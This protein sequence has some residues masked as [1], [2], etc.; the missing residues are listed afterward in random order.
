TGAQGW[1]DHDYLGID[2]GAIA[3]MCENLHSGFVWK[4]MSQNPY[5]IRGLKRAGFRGGWLGD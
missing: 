2:Q 3:L 4:V 5:V 1:F